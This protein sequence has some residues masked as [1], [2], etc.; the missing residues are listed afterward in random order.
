MKRL[1]EVLDQLLER[2]FVTAFLKENGYSEVR[3]QIPRRVLLTQLQIAQIESLLKPLPDHASI[4]LLGSYRQRL[5]ICSASTPPG[6]GV[7]G[8]CGY[9][10]AQVAL[11]RLERLR[12]TPFAA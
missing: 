12:A 4:G 9:H 7:H 8:M 6:G 3:D 2:D 11:G 10:A 5:L 1:T